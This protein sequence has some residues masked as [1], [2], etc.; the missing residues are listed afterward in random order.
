MVGLD[1]RHSGA[2]SMGG[3]AERAHAVVHIID[4]RDGLMLPYQASIFAT[5]AR[6][7]ETGAMPKHVDHVLM[8]CGDVRTHPGVRI[9]KFDCAA[10]DAVV[11]GKNFHKY[12]FYKLAVFKLVAYQKLILLDFDSYISADLMGA[13]AYPPPAMVRW[14]APNYGPFQ[15]NGGVVMLAPSVAMYDAAL[16]W[17]RKLPRTTAKQ[18]RAKIF[19]MRSPWGTFHNR[20][21]AIDPD[22][23]A[24][25]AVD[26][27]QEYF[28]MFWNVLE[29]ERF[30]PL[31]ELPFEYNVKHYCLSQKQWFARAYLNFMSRP[32]QGHIRIVHFNRDKPWAGAQCG[33]FHHAFWHAASRAISALSPAHARLLSVGGER[34][35]SAFVREGMRH[36]D[37]RPCVPGAKT[38]SVYVATLTLE[39]QGFAEHRR[40]R[41]QYHFRQRWAQGA[42]VEDAK[43]HRG[44]VG[45][46]AEMR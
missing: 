12:I 39:K 8:Q 23:G 29:R 43:P 24:V 16:S 38:E 4:G 30:G 13:F 10:I 42:P 9:E 27:D 44:D 2:T 21:R 25:L 36:E 3:G 15:P 11:D 46:A 45:A 28:W 1:L 26:S 34:G 33:P 5:H 19:E 20:S 22:P 31:H 7:H 35:L 14:E 40:G 6:L 17:L 41:E 37:A 32:E 18:R